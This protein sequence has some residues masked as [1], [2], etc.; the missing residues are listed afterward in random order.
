MGFLLGLMYVTDAGLNLLDVIDYYINFIMILVG[1]FETYAVGWAFDIETQVADHGILPVVLL[2]I[3]TFLSVIVASLIWFIDG[4]IWGGFVALA[5]IYLVFF[6]G[7]VY[8]LMQNGKSLT[9]EL[10]GLY[11]NNITKLVNTLSP[12]V[13]FL[14]L[15]WAI[16]I[17]HIITPIL[18]I[19]FINLTASGNFGT[20]GGYPV[21]LQVLGIIAMSFAMFLFLLGVVY[22]AAYNCFKSAG[23]FDDLRA[24]DQK[25]LTGDDT[26]DLKATDQKEVEMV[27]PSV[28]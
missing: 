5:G 22:P 20:Y 3:G 25:A 4:S 17:K 14:P 21:N 24:A 1:F 23:N 15:S 19:L 12:I 2:N 6:I 16:L 11:F 13:G 7:V 9:S 8:F 28:E 18:M 27:M 26:D 10:H